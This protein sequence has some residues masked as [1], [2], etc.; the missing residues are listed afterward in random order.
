[1]APLQ[2]ESQPSENGPDH[3]LFVGTYTGKG[4]RGIYVWRFDSGTGRLT[5]MGLAAET[6]NPSYLAIHPKAWFL[7]AVNETQQFDGKPGGAVTSFTIDPATGMLARINQQ[8]TRGGD[9]CHVRLD[10]SGKTVW[11]AN[12]TGGSLIVF[13]VEEGGLGNELYFEQYHGTGPNKQRQEAPHAHSVSIS[14]D[15]RWAV[16]ADLGTDR[17]HI[18]ELSLS[19]LGVKPATP[20]FASAPAGVGPRHTVFS[21]DGKFL[22]SVNEL[23]SSL[24][25]YSFDT[26]KGVIKSLHTISA[27]PAGFKGESSAAAVRIDAEG[28]FLYTSNRGH[29]SIAVFGLQKPD[30]P[31]LIGHAPSGGKNPRDFNLDPTGKWVLVANQDSDNILVYPRDLQTGML[32]ASPQMVATSKPVCLR[33]LRG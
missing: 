4:S 28:K 9:P 20:P 16:V 6:E 1:M 13:P 21:R 18:Y 26:A 2:A 12:Y 29:D 7:Y 32:K 17:L 19:P 22:Y 15:N 33:F 24:T 30:Q 10:Q 11:V 27:L 25:S 8:P 31:R 5:S 23:T 3:L 14:R